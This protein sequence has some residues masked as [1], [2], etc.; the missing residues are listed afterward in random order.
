M[1]H[2]LPPLPYAPEA[3]EPH[4]DAQTMTIHHGKHH[5]AY[6]TNLN[7]AIEKAPELA[8]WSLD[9]LCSKINA[10]PSAP[11]GGF[12]LCTINGVWIISFKNATFHCFLAPFCLP[13]LVSGFLSTPAAIRVS[14]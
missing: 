12:A 5:Q 10:A 14:I 3:L 7:A 6:V 2:A 13:L 11:P 4:L 9:E 1:A 8:G